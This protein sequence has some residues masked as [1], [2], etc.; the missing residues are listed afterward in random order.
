IS[1]EPWNWHHVWMA[2]SAKRLRRLWVQFSRLL[3][4]GNLARVSDWTLS[5]DREL[6]KPPTKDA[7]AIRLGWILELKAD[8]PVA[9]LVFRC[10]ARSVL[11]VHLRR[12]GCDHPRHYV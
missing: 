9:A 12:T 3:W 6:R 8:D 10:C 5:L 4:R 7:S 2:N 11:R 1:G